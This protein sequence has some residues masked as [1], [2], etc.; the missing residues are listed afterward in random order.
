MRPLVLFEDHG[1]ENLLPMVY[2]RSVFELRIGRKIILDR[3]AQRLGAP[4]AGIWTRDWIAPVA[5]QRCG[6]PANKRITEP[7]ILING[8]WMPDAPA[9]FPAEPCVGRTEDGQIAFIVCDERLGAEIAARDMLTRPR[10]ER[11]V[12]GLPVHQAPGRVFSFLWELIADLP[13]ILRAE[14][15][16]GDAGIHSDLDPDL[17]IDQPDHFHVGERTRIHR[18]A[19]L[20]TSNGP[21]FISDDVS[22]GPF[23]VVEGPSYIGPGTRINPHAWLHGATAIGPNCRVGGEVCNSVIC[24][25]SNK[26]HHGFLGH[27]YVG[28]WVNIGAG[29]TNSNLKNTYGTVR[30][31]IN[32]KEV[33][34]GQRFFGAIIGD[35]AK[36]GI[37]A[38]VPTG[39]VLGLA[40]S[41]ASTGPIP[42][43]VP[44]FGWVRGDSLLSGDHLRALDVAAEVMARRNVEM[45]DDEV[46]LFLDLGDRA[47]QIES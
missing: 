31:P 12:H 18:N 4:V 3:I 32:G 28:S 7:T 22:I 6:A 39:A 33:D 24:G 25:Y 5:A 41:V 10:E 46:E 42:K 30:V 35:H 21:I 11:A 44:S 26:Q 15:N 40:A 27:A 43:F 8:R 19:V 29:A 37:N 14:W 2:W 36:I 20:D 38:A 16:A 9:E 13:G 45:T 47:R 17:R 34:S 1:L 23:V